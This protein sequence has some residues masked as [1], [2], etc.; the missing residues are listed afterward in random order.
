MVTSEGG[1]DAKWKKGE[2]RLDF[3]LLFGIYSHLA[4][5]RH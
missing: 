3:F 5:L 4:L 1:P 2:P